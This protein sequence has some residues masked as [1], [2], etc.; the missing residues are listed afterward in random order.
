[1]TATV[2]TD[3]R[4]CWPSPTT[5]LGEHRRGNGELPWTRTRDLIATLETAGLTGRGGAAFPDLAQDG[6]G[7]GE[8]PDA[9]AGRGGQRRRERARERQGSRASDPRT[10][11]GP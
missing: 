3:T 8:R 9:T 4:A 11:S 5:D 2:L 1:M 10:P 6:R 7:R